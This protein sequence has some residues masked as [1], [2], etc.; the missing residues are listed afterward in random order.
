MD[1]SEDVPEVDPVAEAKVDE[2]RGR[3]RGTRGDMGEKKT[4]D[5]AQ[6]DE[7][8]GWMSTNDPVGK[9]PEKKSKKDKEDIPSEVDPSGGVVDV[10]SDVGAAKQ[11]PQPRV[12][13]RRRRGT[14]T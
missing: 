7:E 11:P 1:V 12:I 8:G 4:S 6:D 10:S 3:R 5:K 13:K 14:D 9:E 2:S